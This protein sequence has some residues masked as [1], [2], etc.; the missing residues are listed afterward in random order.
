MHHRRHKHLEQLRQHQQQ[1]NNKKR[2]SAAA[3][4]LAPLD[5]E[6]ISASTR[7]PASASL[8][9]PEPLTSSALALVDQANVTSA[10]LRPIPTLSGS[11]AYVLSNTTGVNDLF[12]P[13]GLQ[14]G[15]QA[16]TTLSYATRDSSGVVYASLV[17]S[18]IATS[19]VPLG[20]LQQPTA[21]S[22]AATMMTSNYMSY[23][24][25][26]P[27]GLSSNTTVHA[28]TGLSP[29]S[30]AVVG[31]VVGGLGSICVV[32][33]LVLILL[34]KTKRKRAETTV[35]PLTPQRTITKQLRTRTSTMSAI[36]SG[37]T[38]SSAQRTRKNSA[39]TTPNPAS[40]F[41]VISGRRISSPPSFHVRIE[42]SGSTES[43]PRS[44]FTTP[45]RRS[46]L[47]GTPIVFR[48][49]PTQDGVGR[50]QGNGSTISHISRFVERLEDG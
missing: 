33:G 39:P 10:S 17:A 46:R 29:T 44:G 23:G 27:T 11:Y 34:T 31:G 2:F 28:A 50:S 13:T 20:A 41:Q 45:S 1:N 4:S 32:C 43:S 19:A 35:P 9:L 38:L 36:T 15:T 30:K 42:E 26:Q 18:L 12:Y 22:T 37:S 8:G 3:A 14:N 5:A 16:S 24:S 48:E 25:A 7:L 47:G 21:S 49:Q 40:G 6:T